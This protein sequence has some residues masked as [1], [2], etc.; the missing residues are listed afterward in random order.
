MDFIAIALPSVAFLF[1]LLKLV[2]KLRSPKRLPPGPWK[3]PLI[4]SLLHMA[5]PLPHRTLKDLAEKYGPL[6]H[7]QL[8]EISA[9]VV[10]SPEMVNEFMK[11]HDIAFASRPPVLAI[12]IVAYNRDDIAFAPYGDY[13]RQMRKIATLELLS[14]K[15]V[16]SFS[17]IREKEVHNLVESISS[18]GSI[19]PID[20][21]EKLF[22]LISSV[23]ARASF[24]NKCKDQDSFLE[25]TNEIISLAGGFNIFD[26]FPSFKLL[27]RL[28]GM[29]QK[30]EMMHQKVD[31]V[32]ENII[33][34][35]IQERADDTHG[36]DHT[37]DLL[38]V[39]LRL[40]DEGLEF[41]ITYTN[42]KAV[43]LN[44]FSGG[45]DTSS[46]TIEW[47]MTELM[48]NPRVMEKA[49]ADLREA[50]KGKQVVN[51]NDIKDLPYL[52]LVMKETMRL[53]TPLPLLVP[54]ECRQEVEIDGYTITVGTKIIINAWA[55]ARDPQYWKDP[56]SFYPERFEDGTVDFK[57]SNY[58]FIP[59]GSGRRMCPGIAFALATVELPLANLL[60]HFDWKLPNEMKP[61]DLD[62]NEFFGATVKKLNHLCLIATR[63]TP[64]L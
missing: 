52:K 62:T 15:K 64:T 56:E 36:N 2:R 55:I 27:H 60:Y 28:T 33:K 48:R 9:I 63:R 51:E 49:Q 4:G 22:G 18:S 17:S 24:G 1:F 59:F 35:H 10:S 6:M 23:A 58:E 61:E 5:G 14:V 19:I 53:H 31:Q 8:G 37:E 46:T 50:L 21:T 12:E 57:G 26:L 34:D 30:F 45:S 42:V 11:T 38:D 41:P 40:K 3:L 20:M 25:L 39:L 43:I 47:A 13:W 44:A 7:L 32:F 54:R 16:G 29:R